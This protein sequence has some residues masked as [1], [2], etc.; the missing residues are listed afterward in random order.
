MSLC[1]PDAA[2]ISGLGPYTI[3]LFRSRLMFLLGLMPFRGFAYNIV[4]AWSLITEPYVVQEQQGGSTV[5]GQQPTSIGTLHH[6]ASIS[7][8]VTDTL[9]LDAGH[10]IGP[11][12][13]R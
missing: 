13:L 9:R 3:V 7:L 5:L 12:V 10:H 2:P 8:A 1:Y 6:P 11:A 4:L